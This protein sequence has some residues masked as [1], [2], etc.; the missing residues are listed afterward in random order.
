MSNVN[1]IVKQTVLNRHVFD[2]LQV[3][4]SDHAPCDRKE[5][6]RRLAYDVYDNP[7]LLELLKSNER[8]IYDARTDMFRYKPFHDIQDTQDLLHL[9]TSSK[10]SGVIEVKELKE[11]FLK[12]DE[13]LEELKKLGQIL[14]L[15]GKDETPKYVYP[16]DSTLYVPVS[17]EFKTL[18]DQIQV[19]ESDIMIKELEKAGLK[20]MQVV[21]EA[22]DRKKSTDGKKKRMNKRIRITNTHLDIDFTKSGK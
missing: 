16:D 8:I 7:E 13:A 11:S 15:Y 14:I 22:V 19:P 18:W 10:D 21:K 3:L 2:V 17:D 6:I 1:C 5:L 9:I 4:K 20:R 12:T